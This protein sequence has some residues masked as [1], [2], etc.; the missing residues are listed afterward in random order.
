MESSPRANSFLKQT[1]F[2]SWFQLV[3]CDWQAPCLNRCLTNHYTG[4]GHVRFSCLLKSFRP[5]R[6]LNVRHHVM[7]GE[8]YDEG[9]IKVITT[10]ESIRRRPRMY[11]KNIS[12]LFDDMVRDVKIFT[13]LQR[14]DCIIGP[15]TSISFSN[16]EYP[17]Y[18]DGSC[19]G[20][21]CNVIDLCT[22]MHV[23]SKSFNFLMKYGFLFGN[24]VIINAISSKL[25]INCCQ[26]GKR[27][28]FEFINS[29]WSGDISISNDANR[30]FVMKCEVDPAYYD[31]A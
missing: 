1:S 18:I 16:F 30:D 10:I 9:S 27:Y 29:K 28:A 7:N 3:A 6:D 22:N 12:S 5:P 31:V 20:N 14:V 2:V 15:T 11:F 23:G 13:G 4:A 25:M 21:Q 17:V 8:S 19:F 26:N 24:G